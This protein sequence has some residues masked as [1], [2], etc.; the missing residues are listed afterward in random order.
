MVT[1]P[2]QHKFFIYQCTPPWGWKGC[3]VDPAK[4]GPTAWVIC[5]LVG[6]HISSL[7]VSQ[8]CQTLSMYPQDIWKWQQ[9]IH[10]MW[11]QVVTHTTYHHE[12]GMVVLQILQNL[13]PHFGGCV[14]WMDGIQFYWLCSRVVRPFLCTH[15]TCGISGNPSMTNLPC[16]TCNNSLGM[17]WWFADPAKILAQAL[18]VCGLDGGHPHVWVTSQPCKIFPVYPQNMW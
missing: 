2:W 14:A 10:G 13:V 15:K 3:F 4:S 8:A 12:D 7:I 9:H 1:H 16:I 17:A 6:W 5:G 11:F 18:L